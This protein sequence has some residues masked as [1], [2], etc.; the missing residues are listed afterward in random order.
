MQA[1]WV[2]VGFD[3]DP[4][5]P[6][7]VP[8]EPFRRFLI[9]HQAT[10]GEDLESIAARFEAR[11]GFPRGLLLRWLRRVVFGETRRCNLYLVD[12]VMT[13]LGHHPIEVYGNDW[14]DAT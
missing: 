2:P 6:L 10:W 5:A 4:A 8:A 3:W 7:Y 13:L 1:R 9:Q 12:E 11:F 14:W